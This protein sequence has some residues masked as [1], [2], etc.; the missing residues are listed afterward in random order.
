M[1]YVKCLISDNDKYL[2]SRHLG[3]AELLKVTYT[4]SMEGRNFYSKLLK[5]I[6]AYL[7]EKGIK[8]VQLP[9][10]LGKSLSRINEMMKGK[11]ERGMSLKEYLS[12]CDALHVPYDFFFHSSDPSLRLP[13][14][15]RE[16]M[17]R[18][19]VLSYRDQEALLKVIAPAVECIESR[20][21]LRRDLPGTKEAA[22]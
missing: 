9:R 7:D 5:L 12:L 19:S 1:P 10:M 17:E 15:L 18:I 2:I 4:M 16:I 3:V 11:T 21:D 6:N 14:E 13:R 20:Q 8:Q 22:T